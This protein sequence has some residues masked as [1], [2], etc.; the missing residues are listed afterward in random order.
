MD[1]NLITWG[2]LVMNNGGFLS[3]EG[4]HG[5]SP[6]DLSQYREALDSGIVKVDRKARGQAMA[7]TRIICD[8]NPRKPMAE[9]GLYRCQALNDLPSFNH[10]ADLTRWDFWVPFFHGQASPKQIAEAAQTEPEIAHDILR[11]HIYTAWNVETIVW[12]DDVEQT[13]NGFT[14]DLLTQYTST[15]IPLINNDCKDLIYRTTV[16]M[17]ALTNSYSSDYKTLYVTTDHVLLAKALIYENLVL[18]EYDQYVA[19]EKGQTELTSQNIM[20]YIGQLDTIDFGIMNEL[21][22]GPQQSSVLGNLLTTK[23]STI[24]T[25]AKTLKAEGLITLDSNKN[26][27]YRLTAK[28]IRLLKHLRNTSKTE[29]VVEKL[30][31]NPSAKKGG[32]FDY[33]T[34]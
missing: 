5:I 11:K 22:M 14:E 8:M 16:A 21:V 18:N 19:E 29:K 12:N 23:D 34:S 4:L 13:V 32:L 33:E 15:T 2:A 25:R 9:E 17:A 26:K 31:N 10:Q 1:R 27:G 30:D 28:G 20:Q 6:S 7:Q 3:I 24:R